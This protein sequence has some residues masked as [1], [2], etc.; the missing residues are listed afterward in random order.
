MS[1]RKL[2]S[3]KHV[4]PS[5]VYII[6]TGWSNIVCEPDDYN[7]IGRCTETFW[8]PCTYNTRSL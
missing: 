5:S 4:L 7:T 1:N 6:Y 2:I 8:S 3:A